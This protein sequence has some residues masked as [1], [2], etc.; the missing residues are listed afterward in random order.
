VESQIEHEIIHVV[1]GIIK[2]SKNEILVSK[3]KSDKHLCGLLE[4][5]GGKVKSGESIVDALK[6]E[7]SEELN[8]QL[9]HE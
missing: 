9:R 4:F 7:M 1:I 6:R 3:R 5:P 2:N 8:I